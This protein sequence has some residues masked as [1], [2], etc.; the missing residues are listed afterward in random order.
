MAE[1]T[2]VA[3]NRHEYKNLPNFEVQEQAESENNKFTQ[4]K[5]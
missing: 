2:S 1:I 3:F 5:C 4:E